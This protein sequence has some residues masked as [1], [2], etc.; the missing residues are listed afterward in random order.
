M[1]CVF[2]RNVGYINM[3]VAA[4]AA[5]LLVPTARRAAKWQSRFHMVALSGT[6][7]EICTTVQRRVLY[8]GSC[9]ARDVSLEGRCA[10]LLEE[11]EGC[12][13]KAAAA[14]AEARTASARLVERE[15]Q[16]GCTVKGVRV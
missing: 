10:E 4:G 3:W 13:R 15:Q 1:L 12:K 11:A 14:A 16:V 7:Y 8:F 2:V 9:R 5:G 6:S